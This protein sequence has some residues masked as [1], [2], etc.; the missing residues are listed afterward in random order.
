MLC[1]GRM[2][3][4]IELRRND[5][6]FLEALGIRSIPDPT[7]AGDFCWRFSVGNIELLRDAINEARLEV[8]RRQPKS[9]TE[10]IATI[11]ADGSA[12]LA[13]NQWQHI[14]FRLLD[15]L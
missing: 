13:W 5:R 11:E 2:L 14:F 7:T 8:W 10:A 15:A 1:G 9:F 12:A 3:E 6:V 4:D